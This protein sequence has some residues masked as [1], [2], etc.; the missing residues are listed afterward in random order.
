MKIAIVSLLLVLGLTG[1]R[2][3]LLST[4]KDLVSKYDKI[5]QHLVENVASDN[6]EENMAELARWL[7][8]NPGKKKLTKALENII[9]LNTIASREHCNGEDF[10]EI[11]ANIRGTQGQANTQAPVR[12]IDKLINHYIL[13]YNRICYP[14][15]ATILREKK[16]KVHPTSVIM[17]NKIASDYIDGRKLHVMMENSAGDE[18]CRNVTEKDFRKYNVVDAL[19]K[20]AAHDPENKY[21]KRMPDEKSGKM[22][23]DTEKIMSLYGKYIYRPCLEFDKELGEY[24]DAF[25]TP[26]LVKTANGINRK[27]GA[28]ATDRLAI[29]LCKQVVKNSNFSKEELEAMVDHKLDEF[30]NR[31]PWYRRIELGNRQIIF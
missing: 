28:I 27:C 21:L 25:N 1:T 23:V 16:N 7:A 18:F 20:L 24:N 11:E 6:V 26:M 12:R 4:D 19:L 5:N 15:Y 29:T 14:L 31:R 9:A 10:K 17:V 22:F 13:E 30:L 8:S 2:A 3:S